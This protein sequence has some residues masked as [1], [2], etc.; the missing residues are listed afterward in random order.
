MFKYQTG[1][2]DK[3][4]DGNA[5]VTGR[6]EFAEFG[7]PCNVQ[8]LNDL[9]KRGGG[10]RMAPKTCPEQQLHNACLLYTKY[11]M[12]DI[13]QRRMGGDLGAA[14]PVKMDRS[15]KAAPANL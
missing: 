5:S 2:V 10:N 14:N 4:A 12:S 15:E 7:A 13:A 6:L 1:W 8:S 3:K 11:T 9:R